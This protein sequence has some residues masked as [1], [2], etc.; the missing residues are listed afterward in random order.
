MRVEYLYAIIEV[1]KEKSIVKAANKL[2]LS[3]K[4]INKYLNNLEKEIGV[5]LTTR[6]TSGVELTEEGYKFYLYAYK[7]IAAF[8]SFS[9]NLGNI[10]KDY[11]IVVEIK[12]FFSSIIAASEFVIDKYKVKF[13]FKQLYKEELLAGLVKKEFDLG[14]V[15]MVRGGYDILEEYG[16]KFVPVVKRNSVIIVSDKHPL[17]SK[18]EVSLVELKEYKRVAFENPFDDYYAYYY[19]IEKKYNLKRG[20]ILVKYLGD[21][22]LFL[23][24]TRYYYFGGIIEAEEKLLSGLKSLRIKEIK[25]TMDVGYVI[26]KEVEIDEV[27]KCLIDTVVNGINMKTK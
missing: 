14:V 27:V 20:N 3:D 22:E 1:Y 17:A 18:D 15:T 4:T 6:S 19:D 13:E 26:N 8:K 21:I 9:E 2:N 24:N 12:N 11:V 10:K 23:R 25:E 16:L 7:T 5:T